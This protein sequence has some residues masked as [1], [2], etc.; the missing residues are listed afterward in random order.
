MD[1][2]F[3]GLAEAATSQFKKIET[4]LKKGFSDYISASL[5][6]TN[7]V[8]T[9]IHPDEAVDIGS[10]YVP[11]TYRVG[12]KTKKD[13]DIIADIFSG[14]KV[15][16][17]GTAGG[18]KSM[19]I[20]YVNTFLLTNYKNKLPIYFEL[21]S[22]NSLGGQDLIDAIHASVRTHIKSMYKELLIE[23]IRSGKV[24]FIL[25]GF[26]EI[27]HDMRLK[28]GEEIQNISS[29]N[30]KLSIL[31]TSRPEDNLPGLEEFTV[32]NCQGMSKL[33]SMTLL[34]KIEFDDE[35]KTSF[36]HQVNDSLYAKHKEFLSNPLM[37][38]MMLLTYSYHSDIPD[39]IH[40]FYQQAFET[41]FQRHDRSKG[42][43][44]R[45][46]YTKLPMDEFQRILEHFCASS[47]ISSDFSFDGDKIRK[48]I[49]NSILYRKSSV[50]TE[51]FL[52]DLRESICLIQTDG[53]ELSFVHRSFQ[54]YFTARF[55]SS[56]PDDKIG[57]AI[58]TV[59]TRS[60]TDSV[61][62]M[63]Y[64]INKDSFEENWAL[65]RLKTLVEIANGG[66]KERNLVSVFPRIF[67]QLAIFP[68]GITLSNS[69]EKW[70]N[71]AI[72][73]WSVYNMLHNGGTTETSDVIKSVNNVRPNRK[74][75]SELINLS[76]GNS[77]IFDVIVGIEVAEESEKDRMVAIIDPSL[78]SI[79]LYNTFHVEYYIRKEFDLWESHISR[80]ESESEARSRSFSS[81]F[82]A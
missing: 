59:S 48:Y 52:S 20:K 18:G 53:V 4:K 37:T 13:G 62:K 38:T 46:S 33:Q 29:E 50:N 19:L 79:D 15:L 68:S 49:S 44:T 3:N 57:N 28:Y 12:K 25:D 24:A 82:D 26:D 76:G 9:L 39:K 10:I 77:R 51:E 56:L 55:I 66:D 34:S 61:I 74:L 17:S 45:K 80:I 6:R 54:E 41:L 36:I 2:A 23:Y 43:Y 35:K 27:D 32:Y 75:Y 65:P 63:I 16:V 14:R 67:L 71:I 72:T 78:M 7:S 70:G 64:S 11:L 22:L 30:P 47:Y 40:I 21:R 8:K 31:V 81:I 42:V 58:D 69:S 5:R 73:L 60:E 1:N